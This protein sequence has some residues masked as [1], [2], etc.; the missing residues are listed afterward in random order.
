VFGVSRTYEIKVG[1]LLE[2][3]QSVYPHITT[4]INAWFHMSPLLEEHEQMDPKLLCLLFASILAVTL[5]AAQER[6]LAFQTFDPLL[7][8]SLSIITF[9]PL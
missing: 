8:L 7:S 4:I 9:L 5:T 3:W 2:Q 1:G 6:D